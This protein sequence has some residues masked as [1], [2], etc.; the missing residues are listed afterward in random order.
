MQYIN[1]EV[2]PGSREIAPINPKAKGT[3]PVALLS[4]AQFNALQVD[5]KSLRFG[6]TGTEA[7][8]V[9]CNPGGT[10]VNGDGRPDLICH[11]DNQ[12]AKFQIGDQSG[13]VTGTSSTGPFQGRGWLKVLA[14][15]KR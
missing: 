15:K 5:Q 12:A 2:K 10:D 3:I 13:F 9:R 14:G 11:F 1:I 4:N 7:S 8:L 6:S